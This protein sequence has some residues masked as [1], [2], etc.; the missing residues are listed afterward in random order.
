MNEFDIEQKENKENST[1]KLNLSYDKTILSYRGTKSIYGLS[2]QNNNTM[3]IG[4]TTLEVEGETNEIQI[5]ELIDENL[6]LTT[7][8]LINF[9][10][11]KIMWNPHQENSSI[12]SISSD[13]IYLYKYNEEDK[14]LEKITHL[15]KENEKNKCFAPITSFDWN[16]IKNNIIGTS[17]IDTT[18]RIW[19]INKN[20]TLNQLIAHDKEV[21][22]IAFSP[23][24]ENVFI[25]TGSDGS[26]RMFDLRD[27]EQSY[28]IY[29][30]KDESPLSR[31]YWNKVSNNLISVLG[32]ESNLIYVVDYLQQEEM[33]MKPVVELNFH[34]NAVN[35]AAWS[36]SFNHLCSVGDDKMCYIWEIDN[37]MIADLP[38]KEYKAES[39]INNI[40]WSDNYNEWV[41][42]ATDKTLELLKI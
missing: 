26:V 8:E 41:A 34:T 15:P 5:V 2:I 35:A 1:K 12:L 19:D 28:I 21:Y 14:K 30:T 37:S 39:E 36:P 33:D 13:K 38:I 29:M 9:L 7:S 25:T 22:D 23:K 32:L 11:T 3:R 27:L 40:V 17:S 42:I 18:C 4:M 6:Q 20:V 31:V 24:D 16:K 10:P